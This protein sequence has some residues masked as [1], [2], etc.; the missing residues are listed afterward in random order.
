[1]A[2]L[3]NRIIIPNETNIKV[4]ANE[5]IT[6]YSWWRNIQKL[7]EN[8]V[9]IEKIYTEL[10]SYTKIKVYEEG[11]T[12]DVFDVVWYFNP[13][14]RKLYLLRNIIENN[15]IPPE[16]DMDKG[17]TFED[18]GW[19]CA[20]EN[21]DL[22]KF[23]VESRINRLINGMFDQHEEDDDTSNGHP[24]GKLNEKNVD[25]KLMKRVNG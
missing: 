6:K 18:N 11:K 9:E 25:E 14:T 21:M 5:Y 19:Y 10:T 7:I 2:N 24:F 1:M 23:G 15:S 20:N 8:D 4:S 13:K 3:D 12:Y 22:S 17:N 16:R